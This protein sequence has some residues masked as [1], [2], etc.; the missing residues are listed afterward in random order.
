MDVCDKEGPGKIMKW[1]YQ[2]ESNPNA[3][4]TSRC[5]YSDPRKEKVSHNM[6]NVGEYEVGR[7]SPI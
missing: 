3:A 2:S 7:F 4:E 1:Q 5:R 6:I